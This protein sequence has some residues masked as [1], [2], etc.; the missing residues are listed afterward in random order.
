MEV[1]PEA[2][3]QP[4]TRPLLQTRIWKAMSSVTRSRLHALSVQYG[5]NKKKD[6][7]RKG[8]S[9]A[10]LAS[11]DQYPGYDVESGSAFMSDLVDAYGELAAHCSTFPAV[12]AEAK[13]MRAHLAATNADEQLL[14][15]CDR[16][17][18][19]LD[20]CAACPVLAEQDH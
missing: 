20:I 10:M 15:V 9:L 7:R 1:D 4:F 8:V 14:A 5:V 19:K 2:R 11:N 3:E 17:V 18:S 6:P 13:A 12:L 16:I